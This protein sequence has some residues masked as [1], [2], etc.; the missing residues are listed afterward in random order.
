M[1]FRPMRENPGAISGETLMAHN[2]TLRNTR[3]SPVD[4]T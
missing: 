3:P 1:T 4:G 2:M